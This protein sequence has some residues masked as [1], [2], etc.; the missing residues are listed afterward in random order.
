MNISYSRRGS[1]TPLVLLHGIG[2]R[3]QAWEPV[4]DK[5][6][7]A[8]DVIAMDLPGFGKSPSLPEPYSVPVAVQAAVRTFKELG[9]E[10]P[11]LAGNSLGGMLALELASAGHASSVTALAPAG[12]WGSA[13]GRIW[14][15]RM[16]SVIRASGRLPERTRVAVM[17]RKSLRMAS[18]SLLFGHPSRVPVEAMLADLEAMAAAPG[19]DAVARAG[20][21]Y[22]FSSPAPAV[23]VTVAWGTR[24]RILWPSQAR[25]AALLLP[26]AQHVSLPG[27]G[28]VPMHDEPETVARVILQTC[29]RVSVAS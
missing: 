24:D 15:L 20:R 10:R 5:L 17:S 13:R 7:E 19:F 27:C 22:F 28:H 26:A 8:H 11:H 29:A 1:G 23:P 16:L 2:H 18:G 21:D 4:L 9:I 3:W 12:F 6:A 25:R 14:A